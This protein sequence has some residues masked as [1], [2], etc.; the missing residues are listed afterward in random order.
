MTALASTAFALA[1]LAVGNVERLRSTCATACS[2]PCS[3]ARSG[4]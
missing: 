1:D 4:R 3:C 2:T